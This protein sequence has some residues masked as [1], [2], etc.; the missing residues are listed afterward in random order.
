MLR[1]FKSF[2]VGSP[3]VEF[4]S[5]FDLAQSVGRL[6]AATKRSVFSAMAREA[7]VGTV[8]DTRVS[9]QRVIPM[10]ANSFKPFFVGRF[11][12]EGGKVVLRGS[13]VTH[14]FSRLFMAVWFGFLSF[15]AIA[16][17]VQGISTDFAEI[18]PVFALLVGMIAAGFGLIRLGQW[19][20]RRDDAWLSEV[21][22][23]ALDG[24]A[25]PIPSPKPGTPIHLLV[26]A[27]LIAAEGVLHV[28]MAATGLEMVGLPQGNR[29]LDAL[30]GLLMLA[31]AYGVRRL[32]RP[33]WWAGFG[34][35]VYW[36]FASSTM[37][38]EPLLPD[39]ELAGLAGTAQ[40]V[41][42]ALGLLIFGLLGLWW[43]A[44]RVHFRPGLDRK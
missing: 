15:A 25:V 37:S 29:F 32:Y 3:P 2:W 36:G 19:L 28:V 6:R 35:V 11:G 26:F 13:F 33:A 10:V 18:R 20:S 39:P 42:S 38:V 30:T 1:W 31:W 22:S 8:R 40:S 12:E 4:E 43:Y 27:G 44:Q 41:S 9:L 17:A 24:A 34:I 5:A 16:L 7:A 23:S 14:W 21:I